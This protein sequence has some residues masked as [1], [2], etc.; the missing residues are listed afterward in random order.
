M[1]EE[2]F[3]WGG[4]YII[5]VVIQIFLSFVF[6]FGRHIHMI[7]TRISKLLYDFRS[8]SIICNSKEKYSK[9][10]IEIMLWEIMM[11]S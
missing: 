1:Y 10:P 7:K 4:D 11:H 9:K 3:L 8:L 6:V 2:C 5:L